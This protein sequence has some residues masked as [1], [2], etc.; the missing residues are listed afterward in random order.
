MS[1]HITDT[2]FDYAYKNYDNIKSLQYEHL[3]TIARVNNL[4]TGNLI[5][6]IEIIT[7]TKFNLKYYR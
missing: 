4:S 7:L 2:E 5:D 3:N 1:Q 6:A